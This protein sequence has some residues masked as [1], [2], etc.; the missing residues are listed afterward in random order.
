M[1]IAS[2]VQVS[3]KRQIPF[4]V[5]V[6]VIGYIVDS[7]LTYALNRAFGVDPY[8]A[9]FPAFAA[10]TVINFGLNRFLTFA[11]S[12]EP[13]A[14]AFLRY[15]MVCALGLAVNYAAYAAAL[16]I[17]GLLGW[18][19]SPSLL[20]LFVAFGSGVAMFVTYFG[21]RKFAFRV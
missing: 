11:H 4:F 17:W 5:A 21:F 12:T 16:S 14:L 9:R 15:V 1:T 10:A 19:M 3:L 18:P 20:F 7:S 13:L 2:P 8:L 6:G